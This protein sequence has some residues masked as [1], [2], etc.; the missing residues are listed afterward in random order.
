MT[1]AC[2][3]GSYRPKW[4][5][6]GHDNIAQRTS[7]QCAAYGAETAALSRC[8]FAT[9]RRKAR[10]TRRTRRSTPTADTRMSRFWS[11]VVHGLTPY[12]PGEQPKLD[13]LVKLNTNEHPC[14]P[15]RRVLD[16][17]APPPAT[18][19]AYPDP[20]AD[21]LKAALARH[22]GV[23][24]EQIF[25]G[26]GSTRCSRTPSWRA[27]S[28][29]E[30]CSRTSPTASIRCIA[31]CTDIQ[32]RIVP[33]AGDFDPRE[34]SERRRDH[35][36]PTRNAPTGRVRSRGRAHRR[37]QTPTRW[38]W[39]TRPMGLWRRRQR[40]RA[41]GPPSQPA[42]HPHLLQEPLARRPARGLRGGRRGAGRGARAGQEQL[43]LPTRS[44]ASRSPARWPR[45]RRGLLPRQLRPGDRDARG[46]SPSCRRSA[47]RCCPG[48]E[49][50]LRP[51]PGARRRR[52]HRR[53]AAS[54]SSCATSRP[55]ASTSS[56]AS[57]VGT[58]AQCAVLVTAL[59]EILGG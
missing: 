34:D 54:A 17:S 36:F 37:R 16:P 41:G 6:S 21:A 19:C 28:T 23:R 57:P 18:A 14:G 3:M 10:R 22:H 32:P 8:P 30:R 24:P 27:P 20:N 52:A 15:R 56:C 1:S 4:V 51:P 39:S 2:R 9:R 7:P 45:W 12:V 11:A 50:H 46:W 25:V 53:C 13:N 26:N 29:S 58:D 40:D 38:C 35:L 42:G 49:L 47:S 55:R 44:T 43:Q 48:G 31:G 59:R 33:L 5:V